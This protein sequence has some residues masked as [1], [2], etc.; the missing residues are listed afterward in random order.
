MNDKTLKLFRHFID[1]NNIDKKD[2]NVKKNPTALMGADGQLLLGEGI[3][4][5]E[6][7]LAKILMYKPAPHCSAQSWSIYDQKTNQLLF[8]KAERERREC[9]S[10]TKIMTAFVVIRLMERMKLEETTLIK[11]SSDSSSVIGTSAELV[12]N[13][14]LTLKQLLYGLMLPSGNDAAHCLAE[15]FGGRLK[16]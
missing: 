7:K 8:G 4:A 14:T 13:D 6:I 3:P 12:E 10:L 9:A 15:Y 1:P 2:G 11:V 16:T 5:S